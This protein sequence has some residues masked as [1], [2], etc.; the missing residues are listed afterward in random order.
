MSYNLDLRLNYFSQKELSEVTAILSCSSLETT[1]EKKH[2]DT[3]SESSGCSKKQANIKRWVRE[4]F[5][6]YQN[7]S[8]LATLISSIAYLIVKHGLGLYFPFVG[9]NKRMLGVCYQMTLIVTVTLPQ[10]MC[11]F[12]VIYYSFILFE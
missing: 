9:V 8:Q 7:Y 11:A 2:G 6:L 12:L 4:N 1:P 10:S 3:D 5:T